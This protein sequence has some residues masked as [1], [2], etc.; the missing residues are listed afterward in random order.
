MNNDILQVNVRLPAEVKEMLEEMA[1][2]EERSLNNFIAR[3]IRT[4]YEEWKAEKRAARR[5]AKPGMK[6]DAAVAAG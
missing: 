2:D 1:A 6:K 3:L 5:Y 4:E